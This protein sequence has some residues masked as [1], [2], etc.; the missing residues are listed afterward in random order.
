MKNK[1]VLITL[2]SLFIVAMTGCTRYAS[3][4]PTPPAA[5]TPE[6]KFDFPTPTL[7][8]LDVEV[9]TRTPIPLVLKTATPTSSLSDVLTATPAEGTPSAG[10]GAGETQEPG[11]LK[12]PGTGAL[13]TPVGFK[14]T[15]V[16][17]SAGSSQVIVPT[18]APQ[19]VISGSPT[20]AIV[21]V[22]YAESI[23]LEI[24]SLAPNT[25]ISIRMGS[26]GAYGADGP[27]VETVTSDEKGV[28][29]GTFKIPA[30][31]V[32][33]GR[34]GVRIEKP[35]GGFITSFFFMNNNY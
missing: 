4:S 14:G 5:A 23:T 21:H 16:A 26:L 20:V 28:V 35:E 8:A 27:I 32:G 31:Y 30:A 17:T 19:I 2:C 1:L 9:A 33:V 3:A 12:T 15:M 11:T 24:S 6:S 7:A 22:V 13:L 18:R 10:G 25:P 34:I 29:T